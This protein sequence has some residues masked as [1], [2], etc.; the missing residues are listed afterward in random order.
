MGDRTSEPRV[1]GVGKRR[2]LTKMM[3]GI[4]LRG[5]IVRA[6]RWQQRGES[7]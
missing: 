5:S 1:E 2:L 6:K 3:E 7:T 4:S